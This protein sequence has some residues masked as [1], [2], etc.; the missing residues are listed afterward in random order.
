MQLRAS[1]NLNTNS[2]GSGTFANFKRPQLSPAGRRRIKINDGLTMRDKKA[3]PLSILCPNRLHGMSFLCNR[4][5]HSG[6]LLSDCGI[7]IC[8]GFGEKYGK[9]HSHVNY[10]IIPHFAQTIMRSVANMYEIFISF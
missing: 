4:P 10:Y 5:A 9:P 8:N 2:Y 7:L 6:S 3:K 1:E